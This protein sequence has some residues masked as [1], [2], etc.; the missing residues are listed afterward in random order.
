MLARIVRLATEA[1]PAERIVCVAAQG[2]TLPELPIVLDVVRDRTSNCGPLE[3]V[4]TG[5]AALASTADAALVTTCDSP[6][7]VPGLAAYLAT[8]LGEHDA[9]VPR[10]E[11]RWQPLTA[12]YRTALA[13]RI[14]AMLAGGMRRVIDMVEQIDTR[15]VTPE[16]FQSID[17]GLQ[18]ARGCNTPEEYDEIIRIAGRSMNSGN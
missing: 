18:S 16:E 2:Q 14:D 10:V 11:G 12:L 3:G 17:P 5:L 13:P 4:A 6:L 15:E 9:V 8:L 7:L 1:V